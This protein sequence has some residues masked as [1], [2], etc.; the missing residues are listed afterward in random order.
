V[1]QQVQQAKESEEEDMIPHNPL[2]KLLQQFKE[3]CYSDGFPVDKPVASIMQEFEVWA[4]QHHPGELRK[5][6][7]DIFRQPEGE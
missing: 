4:E 3:A 5:A 2:S 1:R 7:E 6:E